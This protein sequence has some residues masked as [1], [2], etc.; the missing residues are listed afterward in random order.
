MGWL[1]LLTI[2]GFALALWA[3]ERVHSRRLRALVQQGDAVQAAHQAL[4]QTQA[5]MD[6]FVA[7][8]GHELRTPMGAILGLNGVLRRAL[9]DRP[10]DVELVDRIRRAAE[11]LLQVADKML[12]FSR[13][14]AGQV[15][16]Y[17]SDF[18]LPEALRELMGRREAQAQRKGLAWQLLGLESVP[19]W[20]HMDRQC[21]QQ[22]LDLLLDNALRHTAQG[23]V[24]LRV[25][26]ADTRLHCE[27]QDTGCGIPLARQA[28]LFDA[29]TPGLGLKVCAQLVHLLGGAL[30][31]RSVPAQ[32]TV[33]WL[34]LPLDEARTPDPAPQADST[35]LA[36]D[37]P[38][39]ILVVDDNE[40]NRMVARLQ[41]QK[42]W[43]RARVAEACSAAQALQ[44]LDTQRFD[45]ALLD[46]VM[47]D[48]DGVA[49][50]QQIRQRFAASTARMPLIALTANTDAQERERCL[51]AGL[52]AVLHKPIDAQQLRRCVGALLV[53]SRGR[54]S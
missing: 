37:A 4:L 30:G 25:R 3:H 23:Q 5:H 28:T 50:A 20:V 49:L 19:Q 13:L 42:I 26:L 16:L 21:L 46:V 45:V 36:A 7:V 11:Q 34:D 32:G 41:L 48:M 14:Q 27:V 15:A 18:D 1:A 2:A 40:V 10:Q 8:V 44:Q 39:D 9:A 43:P 52:D 51:A 29:Q 17:P 38:L 31:V 24:V 12:T 22:V 6:D 53:Q 35:E 47:P 54:A 33:F